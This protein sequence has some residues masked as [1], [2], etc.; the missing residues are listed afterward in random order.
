MQSDER[1]IQRERKIKS[2]CR[3]DVKKEEKESVKCQGE[4]GRESLRKGR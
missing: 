1:T 2:V 3:Y 4:A